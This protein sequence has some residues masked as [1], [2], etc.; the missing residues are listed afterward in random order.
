MQ[1]PPTRLLLALEAHTAAAAE[2][3]FNPTGAMLATASGD[4][5]VKVWD[6]VR[7]ANVMTLRAS[8]SGVAF[9][10]TSISDKLVAGAGVDGVVSVW[11]SDTRRLRYSLTGHT[12]R[13]N[14]VR[15]APDGKTLVSAGKD[16]SA[17]L[18]DMSSG[19]R[20]RSLNGSSSCLALTVGSDS[21][22]MCTG[23]KDHKIRL[24]D[25]RTGQRQQVIS[26]HEST[27]TSL[28]FA[29]A[30]SGAPHLLSTSRDGC[31]HII[32]LRTFLP[33]QTLR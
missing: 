22:Q 3:Q 23:H 26:V 24:W 21:R 4:C 16:R 20:L 2:A 10:S 14:V 7:G 18:W 31:C 32:D 25:I 5:T 28:A 8:G 15:F 6:T 17:K 27:V 30:A 12:G 13:V 9:V 19:R 11:Q 29:P 33:V 1:Q